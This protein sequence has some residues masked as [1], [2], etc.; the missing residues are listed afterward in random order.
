MSACQEQRAESAPPAP[1]PVRIKVVGGGP[2]QVT[3]PIQL[4]DHDGAAI[5]TRRVTVLCRCGR[6]ATPP[7]CDGAHARV[8]DAS[9]DRS[10]PRSTSP[11]P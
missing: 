3:G 4:L 10:V 2:L 6:S 11:R 8:E 5:P 1:P 7:F 9:S